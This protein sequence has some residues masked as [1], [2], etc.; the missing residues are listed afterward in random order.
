MVKI[1]NKEMSELTTYALSLETLEFIQ[2]TKN[3]TPKKA[4]KKH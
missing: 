3:N 4:K 2:K 1:G